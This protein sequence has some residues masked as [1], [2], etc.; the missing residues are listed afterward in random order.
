MHVAFNGS[1]IVF[2]AGNTSEGVFVEGGD[3]QGIS[4]AR[5]Q[6]FG[7]LRDD[8]LQFIHTGDGHRVHRLGE[9]G[10]DANGVSRS[11]TPTHEGAAFKSVPILAVGALDVPGGAIAVESEGEQTA[12]FAGRCRGGADE[13]RHIECSV[14]VLHLESAAGAFERPD[15]RW[16]HTFGGGVA[17]DGVARED[18]AIAGATRGRCD[19]VER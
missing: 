3:G 4:L 12:S 15:G 13:L 11:A 14:F 18:G 7:G 1:L 5:R 17:V 2:I 19:I 8:F 10:G 9:E 6:E 16:G